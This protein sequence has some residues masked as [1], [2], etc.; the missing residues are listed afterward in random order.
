[1]FEEVLDGLASFDPLTVFTFP[2]R[3]GSELSLDVTLMENLNDMNDFDQ[4]AS[5]GHLKYIP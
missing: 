5:N 2:P 1:M 3:E 4:R